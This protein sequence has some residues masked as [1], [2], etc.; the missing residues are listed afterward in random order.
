MIF[1]V[2]FFGKVGGGVEGVWAD[3]GFDIAEGATPTGVRFAM[4][5]VVGLR[6]GC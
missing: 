1:F 3:C 2:L 6:W 5:V 4:F